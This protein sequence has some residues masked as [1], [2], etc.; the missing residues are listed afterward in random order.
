MPTKTITFQQ[1]PFNCSLANGYVAKH[2]KKPPKIPVISC[3]GSCLRGEI[4]RRAANHITYKLAPEKTVRICF[5][6]IVAGGCSEDTLLK[7]CNKVLFIE[8][9]SL[10]CS[11]RLVNGALKLKS[12]PKIIIAD[13][14]YDFDRKLFSAEEMPE[15]EITEHAKS[16]AKKIIEILK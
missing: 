5:Q 6:G 14:L 11:F 9:C 8:G 2:T 1:T 16:V 4:S 3:E 13:K 7:N 12:E 15:E 10:K